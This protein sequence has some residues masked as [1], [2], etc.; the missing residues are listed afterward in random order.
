VSYL[1]YNFARC[2]FFLVNINGVRHVIKHDVMNIEKEIF[3]AF[4]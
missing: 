1:I 2:L 3:K 4:W